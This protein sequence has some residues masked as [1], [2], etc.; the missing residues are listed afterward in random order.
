MPMTH[1]TVALPLA[2]VLALLGGLSLRTAIGGR[3]GTLRRDGRLGVRSLPATASDA[4]FVA[5]NKV[6]API[7]GAA[8]VV[9]LGCA[10]VLA[11]APLPVPA[12][13]LIFVLGT[14]GSAILLVQAGKAGDQVARRMPV[15]ARR[16]GGAA[17]AGCACGGGGC[18]ALTRSAPE[19]GQG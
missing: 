16:P 17:C 11:V 3:A 5:A 12:V 4:A 18:S 13:L 7:V 1:W 2:A 8:A 6:A 15:P 19:S 9:A 14:L 10:L